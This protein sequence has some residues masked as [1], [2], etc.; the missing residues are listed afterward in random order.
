L[1][2]GFVNQSRKKI[3]SQ[4]NILKSRTNTVKARKFATVW[5]V[6]RRSLLAY[7]SMA[8]KRGER[9]GPKHNT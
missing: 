9:R 7:L 8:E 3:F 5:Q 1:G 2:E 6:D 4:N